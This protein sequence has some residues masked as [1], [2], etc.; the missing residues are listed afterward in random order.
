MD[1]NRIISFF[2]LITCLAGNY[3]FSQQQ[4]KETKPDQYRAI[5]WTKEDGLP[6]DNFNVMFKDVM[7]FLWIGSFGLDNDLCRF[8]GAVFKKYIPDP[9]K[10]GA[11]NS[12]DITSFT[13]DSIHNIWIGTGKGLSRYDIRADTFTNFSPFIDSAFADLRMVPFGA[14]KDSIYC[15][16]PGSLITAFNIHTLERKELVQ[17]SKGVDLVI[18]WNTNKSFFD[19]GSNSI[20]KMEWKLENKN[21]AE[22]PR[23]RQIFLDGKTPQDYPWPCNRIKVNHRH[24]AED[25]QY[26]AKRNSIWINSDDGLLEFT[27]ADKK[28]H[29]PNALNELIKLNG[30]D[31]WVGITLDREGN[32]W[33]ATR[34]KGILIYDPK[35]EKVQQLF[36]DTVLQRN[37]GEANFHIYCDRDGIVWISNWMKKGIYEL[38]PFNPLMKRYTANP[39][40]KDSLSSGWI[41]TIVPGP[42]GK[43]WIGTADGLNI[44]DPGTETFEVLRE[45]DLPDIKGKAIIPLYVDTINQKAWLNAGSQETDEQYFNMAMYEMDIKTRKCRRIVFMKG[46][47][48]MDT[49]S[50]PHALVSPY[51]NGIILCDE[52]HGVF[53]IKGGSLVANLL[54]PLV[55]GF[56]AFTMVEDR[57]IFLQAG[58]SLPNFSFENKNGKWT[59]IPHLLDSL[60][61]SFMLYNKK[62]K[63]YWVS[64]K[65]ELIHYSKEFKE[66]KTYNEADGYNGMILKMVIDDEGNLWF[67]NFSNQMGRLDPVTG[68]ITNLSETDG[69]HKQDFGWYVPGTKDASGNVYFGI[70]WKTGT[71]EF[72]WGLDRIYPEK[73]SSLNNNHVYLNSLKVNQKPF[74]LSLGIN[75]LEELSLRYNQNTISIETGIIDFYTKGKSKIRYKLVREGK[76][77]EW[78][79]GTAYNFIRYE[80]LAPGN[81]KLVMQASNAGNEFNGPEKILTIKI[82]TPFWHTWWFRVLV[83]VIVIAIIYGIIQYRSSSLKKRNIFLEKKVKE[84]TS[85]LIERTNE[86]DGS[87]AELKTTQDQLIQSEKMA[88][89]GELT[90]G[91]A[92]EIKNPL[93]FI[94][95]F[96][97]IN[98]ELITEIDDERPGK[99]AENAQIIKTLKKNLEKIHHHGKRVDD[100]VKSMLQHSRSGNL[101]KEPVNVNALCE[102]SLKLAYHGFKAREKTFHASF[103]TNFDPGLPQVMAIPQ[104]LSRVLLNLFNNAFYA[105]QEKKKKMQPVSTDASE[106]ASA[107]KPMVTASTKKLDSKIVLTISDNG[108]GIPQKIINKIFQPFFTT[109]PAGEG[110]GLGLSM[111]YDIITKSHGGELHVKSREGEG[112]D[113]EIDFPTI[114]T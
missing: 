45:K 105:V 108:T 66:I 76:D 16:E 100:I 58:G 56:G 104:E 19:A 43:L 42:Q 95:N 103:E 71:G 67:V 22:I 5:H 31:R 94:N 57:Y 68:M 110:T 81:F 53:E 87:L 8:D 60:N 86:L 30:Y 92:H 44:F 79:Y 91:I 33:Q 35:T 97:E 111:S 59:K 89:L 52:K 6:F 54:I 80:G 83:A 61:W 72:H 36:S 85:E 70:G 78:Q 49:F 13:E 34:P 12:G 102:E 90:S 7:G 101:V 41:T 26:D 11:I 9:Y 40:H 74:P 24:D 39:N 23:I 1:K 82:S 65:R 99:E 114:K 10:R 109:K 47:T 88:S 75:N 3:S 106:I 62:D 96:S 27:L 48:P 55:S 17:L 77:E 64:L 113:F 29:H 20:W 32:I 98:L 69:Y 4:K 84:R 46:S 2:L 37:T 14:T 21:R 63:T 18:A 38:L 25:M 15:M 112:T 107:Y 50:I 73:Y 51:K 28:F 93:N